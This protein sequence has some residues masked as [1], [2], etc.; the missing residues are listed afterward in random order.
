[1]LESLEESFGRYQSQQ[2]DAI[3]GIETVKSLGAE[4]GLRRA[5]ASARFSLVADRIFRSEFM[6]T[7]YQGAIQ[8]VTFLSLGALSGRRRVCW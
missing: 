1:M 4:E 5:S 2:I 6:I 7:S 3:R 8:L